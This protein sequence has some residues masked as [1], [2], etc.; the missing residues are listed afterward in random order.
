VPKVSVIIPNYNHAPYLRQRIDSVLNQTYQDFE[1]VILDDCS[2]DN[3]REIIKEYATNPRVKIVF[4]ESNSGS[5][6]KQWNKGLK[7]A[8][9][10]YVWLAESDDYAAPKFLETMVA[11]LDK[12]TAVG[13]AFC[14]SY[15]VSNDGIKPAREKWYGEFAHLYDRDFR[16]NGKEY[17]AGQMLFRATIPNASAVIFRRVLAEKV[18]GADET[19]RVCGDWLFWARVLSYSDLYY[20]STPLNYFR[21]HEQTARY[22]NLKNGAIVEEACRVA[23]YI[24]KESPVSP[25]NSKKIREGLGNWFIQAMCSPDSEIPRAR[26]RNMKRLISELDSSALR[27]LWFRSSGLQ[28]LWLG[29]RRRALVVWQKIFPQRSAGIF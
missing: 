13:V 5:V 9:G 15:Q 2:R 11:C 27:R 7:M 23:L 18:G 21:Y 16:A 14:D 4:N 20:I 25:E 17:V 8:T 19:F 6:F 1:V 26:Q 29:C 28:W 22:T 24:L 12:D 3:S 10:E